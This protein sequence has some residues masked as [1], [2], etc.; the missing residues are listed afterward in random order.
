MSE[1]S[2]ADLLLRARDGD[3]EALGALLDRYRA[4]L[5]ILAQRKL[6]G[7][8]QARVDVSDVV[9]QTYLEAHRDFAAFQGGEEAELIGWLRRILEH[10]AAHTLERH[11]FTQKR[12]MDREKSLDDSYGRGAP[13]AGRVPADQTSPSRRAML[14]EAAARL[15]VA[16]E[17]LPEDQR[18][19][20][21]LRHLEGWTLDQLAD[22]FGRSE[23]AVAG[24]LKRGL[25]GL[26]NHFR[27]EENQP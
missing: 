1:A 2:I 21:R 16:I 24:L 9:Q 6:E 18:E 4:Y 3:G 27:G 7:A 15:A 5:R 12:T 17:L 14:G 22:H 23:S 20:I 25:R 10:N 19:A 11:L 8:V 13:L 26:R